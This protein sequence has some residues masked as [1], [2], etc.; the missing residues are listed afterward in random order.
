MFC[1][2]FFTVL[3]RIFRQEAVSGQTQGKFFAAA[4]DRWAKFIF[5]NNC[6]DEWFQ[7]ITV[8]RDGM[9]KPGLDTISLYFYMNM[10]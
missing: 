9:P 4:K 10:I 1:K 2:N 7:T 5:T 3:R 8:S 6:C